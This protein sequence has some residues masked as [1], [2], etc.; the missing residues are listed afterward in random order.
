MIHKPLISHRTHPH[1]PLFP[2]F[3][4][5]EN[6]RY[7]FFDK[8]FDTCTFNWS[9]WS[10]IYSILVWNSQYWKQIMMKTT[11][12]IDDISPVLVPDTLDLDLSFSSS[13]N[14]EPDSKNTVYR[15]NGA[16][17]PRLSSNSGSV[18]NL[19]KNSDDE[20]KSS[21]SRM[22]CG[23]Y[24]SGSPILFVHSKKRTNGSHRSTEPCD[25][26]SRHLNLILD[27]LPWVVG[28]VWMLLLWINYR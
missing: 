24:E 13:L 11:H 16:L 12:K 3:L 23:A 20:G 5:S 22:R 19:H 10:L 15:S 2:W 8:Y 27:L 25:N 6:E 28:L 4:V 21:V 7:G 17:R 9:G 1:L 26:S 18:K 14:T